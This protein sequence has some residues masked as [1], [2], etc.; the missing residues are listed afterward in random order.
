MD[1]RRM[2][3]VAAAAILGAAACADDPPSP[4]AAVVTQG[5]LELRVWDAPA[6]I[7]VVRGGVVLWQTLAGG[8]GGRGFAA[9]RATAPVLGGVPGGVEMR[10]G[11][12]RFGVDEDTPWAGTRTLREVVAGP[13]RVDF[14]L[15]DR[16]G[17]LLGHGAVVVTADGAGGEVA[18]DLDL[19]PAGGTRVAL[20]FECATGEHFLGLGGQSW[21]VDH[22]GQT[23]PL[24][25]QEDGIGKPDL[26]DDVYDG[27]WALTG[28]RHSTHTPMPM[29]LSSRGWALAVD[30]TRRAIFELGDVDPD[31]AV[32]EVWDHAFALRLFVGPTPREAIA[33]MTAWVGR[34]E[35]PPAFAFAP[36]L[37]AIYGEVNVRRV[38]DALR[39]A[40]V[41]TSAIWTED[42]RGGNDETGAGAGYVLEE[43]WRV[44]RT[45]YPD[46]EGLAD[47]LHQT[48]F[49][50]LTYANTFLDIE[51]DV[52][53]EAIALGH[54]IKRAD[55]TPYTFTGVKFRDSTM[56]DLT[57][58]AAVTW[59]TDVYDDA[60][61][62]GS[63]GW[64][65]DFAEWLPP[66][67]TL[68]SG[69]DA[70]AYHNRYAV[71]WA[72]LNFDLLRDAEAAD[73]VE[74]LFFARAA[75]LGSQAY[76]HVL[77]AGDQQTDWSDGD[78]L[79]SVIPMG[80]GLGLTGFPY[81]G[82]DIAG[83]MSQTTVPVTKELWFRWVT[84]GALSPVMRTH[85]GRSARENWSWERDAAST[86]HL[87]RWARLHMQLVPY[88]LA[89]AA[90]AAATGAPLF[91]PFVLDYPTWAP[92][93]TM[94]DEYLL[95][96]RIAVAPI[97]VEGATSRAVALPAGAWYGLL[98]GAAVTSDG[99]APITATAAMA[100]IPAF[101]PDC[102]LLAMYPPEVD[103]V[104]DAAPAPGLVTAAAIGDDR[105][106]WLYPCAGAPGAAATL[107]EAGGLT[108]A[109]GPGPLTTTGAQWNGA[110]VTFSAD[111]PWLVADVV[112]PGAL[113]AGA[114]ELLRV[115]GGAA[116]RQ[117][118]LR[119][120]AP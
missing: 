50:F 78:G 56:L 81:F 36:W 3:L 109:R 117:L 83:Y 55:G 72:R 9:T 59:A 8:D 58:P 29:M 17:A 70:L 92:G 89:M 110:P 94:M 38:A 16:G 20:G 107:T 91:R 39:A 80:I 21:A 103:T 65:A 24:W 4:P 15:H 57:S 31:E 71:D 111:G 62:I 19:A 42:W 98:D 45:I 101:V 104:V 12:F 115:T 73:G 69:E 74:R 13:D 67:A 116:T 96:D 37:D 84:F 64:M 51:A 97:Q 44:D 77:W 34:P 88:Q 106:V 102:T 79:P 66:D 46:F 18:L 32:L 68:A 7:A 105:E 26:D 119:L 40:D 30:T 63:D 61:A 95:G 75:S 47:H 14:A 112:G 53:D 113:T 35:V 25:V 43:D 54:T 28:R 114:A 108:Y 11:A 6:R 48:G 2:S 33:R 86:A 10:F 60:I 87:A 100:E 22:R 76:M 41:P 90:E 82:H 1:L 27:I 49:K 93:W 23:V 52:H 85:H 120:V 118:R 99:A 5:E